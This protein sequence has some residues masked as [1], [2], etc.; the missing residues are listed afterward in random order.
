M[1]KF[2]IKELEKELEEYKKKL[3]EGLSSI[4]MIE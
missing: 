2:D 4:K 1:I 3:D